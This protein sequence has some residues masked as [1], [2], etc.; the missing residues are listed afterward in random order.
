MNVDKISNF[1]HQLYDDD[2]IHKENYIKNRH[3]SDLE[4]K[5]LAKYVNEKIKKYNINEIS[6][7]PYNRRIEKFLSLD[8]KKIK[9]VKF[10]NFAPIY[11]N[12]LEQNDITMEQHNKY[13]KATIIPVYKN[14]GDINDP[15]NY[16]Y[17]YNFNIF[18]KLL[19]TIWTFE[20]SKL[21]KDKIDSKNYISYHSSCFNKNLKNIATNFTDNQ[22]NKIL[23]D[24]EKAFDNVSFATLEKLLKN[25]LIRKIGYD[26]GLTYF[27]RYFNIIKKSSIYYKKKKNY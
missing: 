13:N 4:I 19:D 3:I 26:E 6:C 24:M 22:D 5:E 9:E 10:K 17:L 25:F 27:Y 8:Y 14:K 23:L 16:R 18:I 2:Y 12:S 11:Y 1:L 21:L 20:I 7:G 15:G